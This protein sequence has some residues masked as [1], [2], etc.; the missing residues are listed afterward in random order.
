MDTQEQ[1]AVLP[2]IPCR[3][4]A[5]SR[6]REKTGLPAG[7]HRLLLGGRQLQLSSTAPGWQGCPCGTRANPSGAGSL[8]TTLAECNIQRVS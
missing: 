6:C 5:L 7:E 2:S 1:L 8:A 3:L 4:V